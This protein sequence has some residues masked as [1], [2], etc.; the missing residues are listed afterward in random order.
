MSFTFDPHELSGLVLI[1]QQ[2][3]PDQRGFFKEVYRSDVFAE[4]GITDTFVQDNLSVTAKHVL[5]GLH[6]QYPP[7]T[8][9]KLV[10]VLHGTIV[11]VVVDLRQD[12][13]TYRK[14]AALEMPATEHRALYVPQ[15]FAHGF[16]A[17]ENDTVVLYKCSSLYEPSLDGGIR[18]NDP[19]IGIIWPVASPRLSEKDG[20]LPFL[21]ELTKPPF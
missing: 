9:A 16:L 2:P 18:W 21:D 14:W 19:D 15:G 1:E 5:R 20:A 11:D 3:F 10:T 17:T 7:R 12:S 6:F 8:Q 4:H 13:P